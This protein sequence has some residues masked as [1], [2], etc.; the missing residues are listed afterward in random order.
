MNIWIKRG[1]RND[2]SV[3]SYWKLP[4]EFSWMFPR[5]I[6]LCENPV[7]RLLLSALVAFSSAMYF[8]TSY[9]IIWIWFLKFGPKF[10][11]NLFLQ[12]IQKIVKWE[13]SVS[14]GTKPFA[15]LFGLGKQKISW[16]LIMD[17]KYYAFFVL[18]DSW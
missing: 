7:G 16:H 13:K 17:I 11:K 14:W 18:K 2:K 5:R 3:S 4:S 10:I 1:H 12:W 15:A 8:I 9:V 6:F